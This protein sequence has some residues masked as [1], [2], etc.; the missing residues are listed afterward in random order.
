MAIA[1]VRKSITVKASVE[2]AFQVFTD[3][4]D[5]WWPR[6]HHIGK[7]PM[8]KAVIETRAGGR[9]YGREADGTECNW[10]TVLTWEPPNRFVLAWQIDPKW[11]YEP[12]VHKASEVEVR[13]TPEAGGLTRVDLEH[14][15][16]ER[17]GEGAGHVR[18]GVDA[19]YGWG[20]LLQTYAARATTYH[21]AVAPLALIFTMNDSLAARAFDKIADDDVWRRPTDRSNPMQWI[22]GHMV[23]TRAQMLKMFGESV[24]TGWGNVF[25]RGASLGSTAGYPSRETVQAVLRDV[26]GRLYSTLGALTD[27]DL[28]RPAPLKPTPAVQTIGDLLAFFT[29]HDT[30][31]I[32]QLAYARKAL[33]HAGV[34]G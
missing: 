23:A 2:H 28:A 13:F 5:S 33:G 21:P 29:L 3:G 27:A 32:G 6:S 11:Q 34:V 26:N 15:H 14:R 9:C 17:H 1:P 8:V 25:A 10:G 31:H 19:P 7:Q 12:D 18:T 16:F 30:Y 24:D 22:L 4:F 20:G